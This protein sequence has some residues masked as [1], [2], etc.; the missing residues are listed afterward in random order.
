MKK[1]I[2][3][4][5][6]LIFLGGIISVGVLA[7]NYWNIS[8]IITPKYEKKTHDVIGDFNN[9]NIE[10]E[11][12]DVVFEISTDNTCKVV[13]SENEKINYTINVNDD[14]LS[15]LEND[16]RKWY[17][18]F[19]FFF[20]DKEVKVYLPKTNYESLII[21]NTTGDIIIPPSLKLKDLTI[22]NTTGDV[23][24]YSKVEDNLKINLTTGRI[25]VENIVSKTIKLNSTTGNV[26]LKNIEATTEAIIETTTGE[27][28]L[29]DMKSGKLT[30]TASTGDIKLN[31]VLVDR[32]LNIKTTTGNITLS[33]SDAES[34]NLKATT[35]EIYCT[36]LS[37][38]IISASSNTGKINVPHSLT[39]GI[40]EIKTTTGNI[41]VRILK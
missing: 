5:I 8:D 20:E 40:C 1:S 29:E 16:N 11:T 13:C 39:G 9:I 4:G 19:G 33:S 3:I 41:T 30:M 28:K 18:H 36:L 2:I 15:I 31:H 26:S 38:K 22:S 35:G 27:I 10:T 17:E 21:G 34:L 32:N 12:A 6:G 24:V 37:D 23:E 25:Y 7:A 14:T